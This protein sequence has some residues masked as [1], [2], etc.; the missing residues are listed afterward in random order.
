MAA[1]NA[2][3]NRSCGDWNTSG[4]WHDLLHEGVT[5]T[6]WHSVKVLLAWSAY[7]AEAASLY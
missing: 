6:K 5:H 3:H 2:G 1:N 7:V 4:K